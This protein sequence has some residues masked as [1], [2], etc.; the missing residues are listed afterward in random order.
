MPDRKELSMNN[1][2]EEKYIFIK[3]LEITLLYDRKNNFL[4]SIDYIY[5]EDIEDEIVA[6]TFTDGSCK[7]LLATGNSNGQNAKEIIKTIY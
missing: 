7:Q 5:R 1:E 4:E 6:I 2:Y 3:N